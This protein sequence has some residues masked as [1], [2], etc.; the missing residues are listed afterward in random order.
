MYSDLHMYVFG[1]DSET[2]DMIK[3]WL[4]KGAKEAEERTLGIN[5]AGSSQSKKKQVIRSPSTTPPQEDSDTESGSGSRVSSEY[6]IDAFYVVNNN[7]FVQL[8]FFWRFGDLAQHTRYLVGRSMYIS[9]SWFVSIIII[10]AM[11]IACS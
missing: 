5:T 9:H 4:V 3:E 10:H 8:I 11:Q 2:V 7:H 1:L 6:T